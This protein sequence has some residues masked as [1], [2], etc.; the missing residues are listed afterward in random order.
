MNTPLP[1]GID[2]PARPFRRGVLDE[3]EGG[4]FFV[5]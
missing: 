4:G 2:R 5:I 1:S 3:G